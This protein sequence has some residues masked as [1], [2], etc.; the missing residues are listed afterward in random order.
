MCVGRDTQKHVVVK[1]GKKK[2]YFNPRT[3]TPTSF[4]TDTYQR[5]LLLLLLDITCMNAVHVYYTFTRMNSQKL[6]TSAGHVYTDMYKMKTALSYFISSFYYYS[7]HGG[8]GNINFPFYDTI[9]EG[10]DLF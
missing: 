9:R 10:I 5:V 7:F 4:S 3:K 1:R 6:G 8:K 2:N